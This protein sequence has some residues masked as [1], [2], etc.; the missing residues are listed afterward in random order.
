[1]ADIAYLVRHGESLVSFNTKTFHQK[2]KE[3]KEKKKGIL[4][5]PIFAELQSTRLRRDEVPT[6]IT[7]A[8]SVFSMSLLLLIQDSTASTRV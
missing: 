8:L 3:K 6:A 7:S 1:M 4:L 2:K 5:H